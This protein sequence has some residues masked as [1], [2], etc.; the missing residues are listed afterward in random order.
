MKKG[1]VYLKMDSSG[2]CAAQIKEVT[3]RNC[4]V[5]EIKVNA[6]GMTYDDWPIYSIDEIRTE[7][8]KVKPLVFEELLNLF[9]QYTDRIQEM[10][11]SHSEP[12]QGDL[13]V[14]KSYT[15]GQ[16]IYEIEEI[17]DGV[18]HYYYYTANGEEI[19]LG[20]AWG[21]RK[22]LG[23]SAFLRYIPDFSVK[24]ICDEVDHLKDDV[25]KIIGKA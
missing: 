14:G 11:E 20:G 15:D 1:E 13:E 17:K 24:E 10:M 21:D 3:E 19:E 22:D 25:V 5:K 12:I 7:R 4:E 23:F 2:L 18:L 8:K 16:Y 6:F 9:H